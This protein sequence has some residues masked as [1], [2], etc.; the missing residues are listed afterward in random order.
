MFLFG[1]A[2]GVLI[3]AGSEYVAAKSLSPGQFMAI[4]FYIGMIFDP[5]RSLSEQ[6]NTMQSAMAASE[7]TF[8]ILDREVLV[9]NPEDPVALPKQMEGAIEFENVHFAYRDE[10]WVLKDLSFR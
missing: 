3:W 5:I 9:A 7:R 6:Y 2:Q 10:D 1:L 8:K 4:W